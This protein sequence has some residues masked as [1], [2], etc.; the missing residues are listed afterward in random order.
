M[1]HGRTDVEPRIP[2]ADSPSAFF[3]FPALEETLGN[4]GTLLIGPDEPALDVLATAPATIP[5]SVISYT[6]EGEKGLSRLE[7]IIRTRANRLDSGKVSKYDS[8]YLPQSP[9]PPGAWEYKCESCRFY[10]ER[11]ATNSEGAVC[12]VVGQQGDPF[13]QERVHPEAWCAHWLPEEGRSWLAWAT[14]RLEGKER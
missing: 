4:P 9:F 1:D 6:V 2:D 3:S 7:S 14:D 5:A 8:Y 11:R 13:G 10:K 12:E